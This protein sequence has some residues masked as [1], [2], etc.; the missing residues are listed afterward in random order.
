[1]FAITSGR[2]GWDNEVFLK[3]GG[4]HYVDLMR[5]LFGEVVEVCGY[6]NTVGVNV[7]QIFALRF[8]SE[9]I[10]SMFFAGLPRLE[11]PLGGNYR[12]R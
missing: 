2:P 9:V 11:T 1:M 12:N 4:I 10:G 3:V 8:D 5:H 7:D 6:T